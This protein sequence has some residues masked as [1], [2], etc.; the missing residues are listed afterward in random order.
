[1]GGITGTFGGDHRN[2]WGALVENNLLLPPF[3]R[4][5]ADTPTATGGVGAPPRVP[6]S[7]GAPGVSPESPLPLIQA[8]S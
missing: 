6:S 4:A 8:R 7:W 3:G 2:I 5:G 1:M